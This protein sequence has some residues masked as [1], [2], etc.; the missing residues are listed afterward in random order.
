MMTSPSVLRCKQQQP[1]LLAGLVVGGP[2]PSGGPFTAASSTVEAPLLSFTGW[3]KWT[4]SEVIVAD[5]CNAARNA[6][7]NIQDARDFLEPKPFAPGSRRESGL[8]RMGLSVSTGDVWSVIR[9][10][11]AG[12]F[13]AE[14]GFIIM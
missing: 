7:R 13:L 8:W 10:W 4:K 2:R 1:V 14:G 3:P 6:A 5:L 11:K 9:A 12:A